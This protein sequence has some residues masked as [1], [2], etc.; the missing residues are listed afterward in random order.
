[1]T[2]I[3]GQELKVGDYVLYS[4]MPFSNY[5]DSLKLIIFYKDAI[6]LQSIVFNKN[7]GGRVEYMEY[8]EPLESCIDI[9]YY[10]AEKELEKIDFNG[11]EPLDFMNLNYAN[12]VRL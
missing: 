2:D 12:G 7:S 4:E 6:R 9:K 10:N 3:K 1:M 8:L 5:A 11:I